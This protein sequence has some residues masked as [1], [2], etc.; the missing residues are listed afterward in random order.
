VKL[1]SGDRA[2]LGLL[3]RSPFPDAPPRWIR[4]MYY[5]YHFTNRTG[6]RTTGRWWT[7]HEIGP[8]VPPSQLHATEE[9]E[10]AEEVRA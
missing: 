3:R 10:P 2:T 4:A 7:R 1:L 8:Y 5:E 9:P 6:R